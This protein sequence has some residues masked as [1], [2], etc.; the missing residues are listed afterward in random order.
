[1]WSSSENF[2]KNIDVGRLT[3]AAD[4]N[5]EEGVSIYSGFK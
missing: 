3:V 5:L 1:M 4:H 2:Y